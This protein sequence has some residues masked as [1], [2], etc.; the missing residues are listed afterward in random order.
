MKLVS[1][2]VSIAVASLISTATSSAP[3]GWTTYSDPQAG[4]AI[5]YPAGWRVDRRFVY[6]GFGPDHEIHGVAFL[7]PVTLA[8]GTNLSASLTGI[9]VETVPSGRRCDAT[10]FIPDPQDLRTLKNA[11]RTWSTANA[12]DAGA[13]NLYD[14]AVFALPGSV[15]CLA[16]RYLIHSTNIGNYDPGSV[17]EFDRAAL[18]RTFAAIRHTLRLKTDR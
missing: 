16:V 15:P 2:L 9:S 5:S 13:G 17:R 8:K 18:I 14:V 6:V 3:G 10:R 11:G 12:Q 1:A 7:I 4:F